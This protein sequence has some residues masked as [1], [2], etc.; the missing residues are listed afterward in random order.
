MSS[1]G[2]SRVE[3]RV[4]RVRLTKAAT[5]NLGGDISLTNPRL[6]MQGTTSKLPSPLSLCGMQCC[7]ERRPTSTQPFQ[8]QPDHTSE[9]VASEQGC[10]LLYVSRDFGCSCLESKLTLQLPKPHRNGIPTHAHIVSTCQTAQASTSPP[11][12][13]TSKIGSH[14]V[15]G[16]WHSTYIS[17]CTTCT[18]LSR[19]YV[20]SSGSR[21]S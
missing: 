11:S 7:T 21:L 2:V 5:P 4:S 3:C 17:T 10:H 19:L 9:L 14:R 18:S 20:I 1:I 13:H 6:G 16:A 12:R 15:D 8:S